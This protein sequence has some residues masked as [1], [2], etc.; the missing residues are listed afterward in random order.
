MIINRETYFH[1]F[2]RQ[3]ILKADVMKSHIGDNN[4]R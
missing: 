2:S 3:K 4:E 1:L